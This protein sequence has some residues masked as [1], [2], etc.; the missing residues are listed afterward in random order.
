MR[1]LRKLVFGETWVLPGGVA[2][3]VAGGALLHAAAPSF[4]HAAG[5]LLLPATALTALV[6]AVWRSLPRRTP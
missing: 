3:M 5:P 6:I 4:W 2:A 1:A